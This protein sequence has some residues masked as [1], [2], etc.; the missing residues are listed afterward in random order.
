MTKPN[1]QDTMKIITELREQQE[2]QLK[3][4]TELREQHEL[5]KQD[6]LKTFAG[7]QKKLEN[8]SSNISN[9]R[10]G[11]YRPYRRERGD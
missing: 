5:H 10:G 4:I 2:L 7:F 1:D 8:C 9:I 6:V 3:M 11:C